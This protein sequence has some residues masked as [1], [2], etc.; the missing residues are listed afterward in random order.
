MAAADALP[1]L[2]TFIWGCGGGGFGV[3]ASSTLPWLTKAFN[4]DVRPS[5]T[6]IVLAVV[7]LLVHAIIGGGA[8]LFMG[9]VDIRQALVHGITWPAVYKSV[10]ATAKEILNR[11][12]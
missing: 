2:T 6:R 3:L 4:D 5:N 10:G 12:S 8:A 7:L 11:Q 1:H 9:S